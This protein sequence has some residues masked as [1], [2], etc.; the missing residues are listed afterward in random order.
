MAGVVG[1]VFKRAAVD[2][3]GKSMGHIDAEAVGAAVAPEAQGGF[4]VLVDL[5]VLPVEV[6]LL[7]SE[8]VQI[9]LAVANHAG[10]PKV[11][12]QPLGGSSPCSPRP[13][14]KI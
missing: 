8:E 7:Y 9:P 4:E 14:R 13:G 12:F 11:D 10:P 1:P 6:G 5:G 3:L 2:V